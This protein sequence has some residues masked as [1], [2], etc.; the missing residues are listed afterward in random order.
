MCALGDPEG[1][2][3]MQVFRTSWYGEKGGGGGG[4]DIEAKRKTGGAERNMVVT[5]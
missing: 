3:S 2:S 5:A 1:G 4:K